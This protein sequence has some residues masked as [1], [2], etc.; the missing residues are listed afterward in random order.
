MNLGTSNASIAGMNRYQF[1]FLE[2]LYPLPQYRTLS[3]DTE[4]STKQV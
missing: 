3:H 2:E 1:H 4:T